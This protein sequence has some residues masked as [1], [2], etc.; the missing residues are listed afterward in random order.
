MVVLKIPIVYLCVVIYHAI[1]AEPHKGEPQPVRVRISPY[2]PRPGFG[3]ARP[4]SSRRPWRPHGGPTR[5]YAR[6]SSATYAR[7]DRLGRG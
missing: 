4:R 5:A 3:R 1:K 2:D 6:M 7:A